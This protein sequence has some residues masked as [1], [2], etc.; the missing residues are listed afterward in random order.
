MAKRGRGTWKHSKA[1]G[2]AEGRKEKARV[3]G[4]IR[5]PKTE[6][7]TAAEEGE[8]GMEIHHSHWERPRE[9]CPTKRPCLL[10]A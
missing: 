1:D 10:S 8:A 7:H 2:I 5:A 6:T 3:R 9:C 4:A